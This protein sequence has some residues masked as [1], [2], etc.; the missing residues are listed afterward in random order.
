VFVFPVDADDFVN[1][2]IAKWCLDHPSAKGFK[3]KNGYRWYKGNRYAVITKYYGGTMNIMKM[4]AEDLS[5]ELPDSSTCLTEA[6]SV[7]MSM[8]YPI[9]WI[10]WQ[11][12]EKFRALGRPLERLPFRSTVYVL[13]TGENIS[14]RDPANKTVSNRFHPV[15]FLRRVNPFNKR[16][17]TK[18]FRNEFG[19]K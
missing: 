13:G 9:R 1:C 11:V 4:F 19:M 15:A 8:R 12:E 7:A 6:T 2:N 16:L 18:R 14:K 10:D 5:D 3:S 17:I